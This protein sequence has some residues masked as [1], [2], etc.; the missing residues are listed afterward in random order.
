MLPLWVLVIACG[1][2]AHQ[3]HLG[4][5]SLVNRRATPAVLAQGYGLPSLQAAALGCLLAATVARQGVWSAEASFVLVFAVVA[6]HDILK[7]RSAFTAQRE[8]V[9]RLVVSWEGGGRWQEQVAGYLDPL[10][11]HPAHVALGVVFGV[12]FALAFGLGSS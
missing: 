2:A 5:V 8:A 9:H 3:I 4:A 1:A 11:H 10:S 7:L 6:I 12:L